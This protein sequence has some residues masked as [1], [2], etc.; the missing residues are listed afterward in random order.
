[1]LTTAY[2]ALVTLRLLVLLLA[3][4]RLT[5]S[6]SF[7]LIGVVVVLVLVFF[8]NLRIHRPQVIGELIFACLLMALSRPVLSRR[9]L[10]LV[11]LLLA[12]WANCHGSFPLGFVL[13]GTALAGQLISLTLGNPNP[14]ARSP[15]AGSRFGPRV[16]GFLRGRLALLWHDSQTRRLTA[17]LL[18]A[19]VAVSVLN[20]H[21]LALWRYTWDLA[22]HPNIATMEEW[23][24]LVLKSPPGYVFLASVLV[25]IPLLRWSPARFT[26]TQLLLLLGFGWQSLGHLRMLIWW[27]MVY[28]WAAV[29]HLQAVYR[30]YLPRFLEDSDQPNFRKTLL[31]GFVVLVFLLWSLPAQWLIRG[32]A[33]TTTRLAEG[34][35]LAVAGYLRNQY[36]EHPELSR[37]V[38]TS[39]TLGDYLL[40]DLR[41]DPPVRVSCYTHVHLFTPQHWNDCIA[42]KAGDRRWQAILDRMGAQFLVVEPDQHTSLVAQVA[43]SGRWQVVTSKPV[44]VAKRVEAPTDRR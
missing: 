12:L 6:V 1:M 8:V 21:G 31:A 28:A 2:A 42:V 32:A 29:P 27:S 9:A 41:L 16:S 30:R 14:E 35:P 5:G 13:L 11:P 20:P 38:F 24:P 19:L 34:T 10:V 3:F 43:A 17:V 23:K 4:R 33:P 22:G 25:L 15:K 44:F 36:Q 40:W 37:C 7:A 39:E 26:P 18:L